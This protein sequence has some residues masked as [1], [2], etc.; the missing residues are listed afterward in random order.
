MDPARDA[1]E[2]GPGY[3]DRPEAVALLATLPV[4]NHTP[5]KAAH[6]PPALQPLEGSRALNGWSAREDSDLRHSAPKD[7][8]RDRRRWQPLANIEKYSRSGWGVVQ[9]FAGVGSKFEEFCSYLAP[10]TG[11]SHER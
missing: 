10:G 5:R 7:G 4:A 8:G 6:R 3:D 11:A 9:R 2:D 1:G